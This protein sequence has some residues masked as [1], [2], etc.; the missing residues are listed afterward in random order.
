MNVNVR[1]EPRYYIELTAADAEM[2]RDLGLKVRSR[3]PKIQEAID[4]ADGWVTY[5][6][7]LADV[8]TH[9][10]R[11]VNANHRQMEAVCRILA[12]SGPQ[13]IQ[14]MARINAMRAL[15]TTA[16]RDSSRHVRQFDLSFTSVELM[17]PL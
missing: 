16:M 4:L 3:H 14:K 15:F 5:I 7:L 9:W 17:E 2:I 13:P 12:S 6:N 11:M 1:A 8:D 10:C